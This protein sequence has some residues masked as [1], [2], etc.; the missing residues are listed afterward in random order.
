VSSDLFVGAVNTV[1]VDKNNN[2]LISDYSGKAVYLLNPEGGLIKKLD[3]AKCDPGMRWQPR[4]AFFR[5]DG[6]II[7]ITQFNGA[8]LFDDGGVCV[9]KLSPQFLYSRKLNLI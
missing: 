5:E 6:K 8:V 7:I 2:I 4:D 9:K 1:D 3:P